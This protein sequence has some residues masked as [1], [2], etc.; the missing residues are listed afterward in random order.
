MGHRIGPPPAEW[1][2]DCEREI[3]EEAESGKQKA[4]I[5]APEGSAECRVRSAE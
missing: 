3:G 4:E 2:I 5:E 1:E